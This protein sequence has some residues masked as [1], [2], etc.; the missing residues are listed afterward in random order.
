MCKSLPNDV[1]FEYLQQ[2]KELKNFVYVEPSLIENKKL[3]F[4]EK[5]IKKKENLI[6][7]GGDKLDIHDSEQI[8]FDELQEQHEE[9]D[10]VLDEISNVTKDLKRT[11]IR[12]SDIIQQDVNTINKGDMILSKNLNKILKENKRLDQFSENSSWNSISVYT[13]IMFTLI[14]F[15]VMYFFIKLT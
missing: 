2:I 14:T 1:C 5:E 9:Q 11:V 13:M 6:Y 15:I 10:R 4:D 8:D 3:L 7:H 12:A